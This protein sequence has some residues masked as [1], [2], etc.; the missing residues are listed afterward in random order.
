MDCPAGTLLR[1]GY[2]A[3]VRSKNNSI[4]EVYTHWSNI[5]NF[6][7]FIIYGEKSQKRGL[8]PPFVGTSS[9]I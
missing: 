3:I 2:S 1:S 7:Y 4:T 6:I 9:V 5:W 8:L